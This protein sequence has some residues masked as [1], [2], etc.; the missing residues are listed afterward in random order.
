[1]Y[2]TRIHDTHASPTDIRVGPVEFKL[3]ARIRRHRQRH[4]R[5]DPREEIARVGRKDVGLS[6]SMSVAWNAGLSYARN[7][8]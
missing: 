4:S 5:D 2:S 6:V 3:R 1:M 8:R 7:G